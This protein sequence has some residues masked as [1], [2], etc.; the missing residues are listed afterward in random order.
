MKITG[1]VISI[2]VMVMNAAGI[3]KADKTKDQVKGY[4]MNICKYKISH[5]LPIL[6]VMSL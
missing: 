3:G 2:I 4:I 5:L 1:T 6:S